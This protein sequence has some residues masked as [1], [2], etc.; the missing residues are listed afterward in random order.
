MVDASG[1]SGH[2]PQTL[3]TFLRSL[4]TL[5]TPRVILGVVVACGVVSAVWFEWAWSEYRMLSAEVENAWQVD[6]LGERGDLVAA[7]HVRAVYRA[8][9][10][11]SLY[12]GGSARLVNWQGFVHDVAVAL[13]SDVDR[14]ASLPER[15]L[16][17]DGRERYPIIWLQGHYVD[18]GKV[19]LICS[20][21][22]RGVAL[23][24]AK[25]FVLLSVGKMGSASPFDW[26]SALHRRTNGQC[27]GGTLR[28]F[29]DD[30][31]LLAWFVSQ[32][33][34]PQRPVDT[35]SSSSS[36]PSPMPDKPVRHPKLHIVPLGVEAEV[37]GSVRRTLCALARERLVLA[38]SRSP[39][40]SWFDR[41]MYLNFN[42]GLE[43]TRLGK[44][45]TQA[46]RTLAPIVTNDGLITLS[47]DF[48]GPPPPLFPFLSSYRA[49]PVLSPPIP[50]PVPYNWYFGG[51][52][53]SDYFRQLARSR[54]V[55]SP[56]GTGFDC[57]RHWEALAFGSIPVILRAYPD[58][59]SIWSS[60]PGPL[61]VL[62]LDSWDQVNRSTLENAW[63]DRDRYS[64][65]HLVLAISQDFWNANIRAA[66]A[67]NPSKT[68]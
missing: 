9:C 37:E 64:A 3:Q 21:L 54:F 58:F 59:D 20:F 24:R 27:D 55:A 43:T 61:P 63:S 12:W 40:S 6:R 31:R 28:A 42:P 14:L 62:L 26:G 32:H 11:P 46:F 23:I 22:R 13:E 60:S 66:A 15:V 35:P 44:E 10:A 25:H 17:V 45:R 57:F 39:T 19:E 18:E 36:S 2:T 16:D 4:S 38:S 48:T 41:W 53:S 68:R 29:L 51:L 67:T 34:T 5:F 49:P 8:F 30:N 65:N 1:R 52:S 33:G 50:P 47:S 56:A 7:E